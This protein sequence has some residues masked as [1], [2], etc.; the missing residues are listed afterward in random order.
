MLPGG[1]LVSDHGALPPEEPDASFSCEDSGAESTTN[2]NLR[3][4]LA[5]G[6]NFGTHPVLVLPAPSSA[7]WNCAFQIRERDRFRSSSSHS[8][9]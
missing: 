4:E 1:V 2:A 9:T 7:Y 5:P 6:R 3:V 8:R